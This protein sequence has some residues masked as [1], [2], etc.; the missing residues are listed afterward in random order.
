MCRT[1]KRLDR[2]LGPAL[3]AYREV[4]QESSRFSPFE[5]VYGW[6]VRGPMTI[7]K[8]LWSKEISDPQL[9]STYEYVINLRDR[10]ESTCEL[11]RE[12]LEHASRKQASVYNRRSNKRKLKPGQKVLIL[13]PTKANKLLMH[14]KGPYNIVERVGDVDYRIIVKGK[15]KLFHVNMLKLYVERDRGSVGVIGQSSDNNDID[16]VDVNTV[17]TCA[18][19]SIIDESFISEEDEVYGE[20][21]VPPTSNS[22]ET[23]E[24]VHIKWSGT[25]SSKFTLEIY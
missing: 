15:L 20:L 12:N 5:L 16:I 10:L 21:I 23:Y 1:S 24:H 13:L 19:V 3:F 14:W 8:E 25:T 18:S 7:L 22:S 17:D 2:Y 4:P 9:R 6:S 11:V